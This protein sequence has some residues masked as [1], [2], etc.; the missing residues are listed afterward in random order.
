ML[1]SGNRIWARRLITVALMSSMTRPRGRLPARVY[2]VRRGVVLGAVFLLVFTV[3]R[4]FSG[5]EEE[6]PTAEQAAGE[7]SSQTS[8]N[9]PEGE[10]KGREQT[11]P[12][13]KKKRKKQLAA[14]D[15]PCAPEE[16]TVAATVKKVPAG[17]PKIEIP[18]ELSTDREACTF[19]VSR[20]T[21]ALKITSGSDL[22]WSSQHCGKVLGSHDVVVRRQQPAEV[23]I[24]W[25]GRRSSD[26]CQHGD[27]AMPGGY[28]AISATLGGEPADQYFE[29]TAAERKVVTKTRKKSKAQKKKQKQAEQR[30]QEQAEKKQ[31]QQ[32]RNRDQGAEPSDDASAPTEERADGD[33]AQEP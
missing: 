4:L 27:W 24:T 19:V 13:P 10:E 5:G 8:S 9:A 18:L 1:R 29:L 26:G 12:A 25:N 31:K 14:P 32:K 7:T 17:G 15:G 2:W 3:T 23:A 30:K 20:R 33:G 16:V 11:A 28:H 21:T 22:I 6:K